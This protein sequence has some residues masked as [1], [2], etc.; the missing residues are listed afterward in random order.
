[1]WPRNLRRLTRRCDGWW[2]RADCPGWM[3]RTPCSVS[4]WSAIRSCACCDSSPRVRAESLGKCVPPSRPRIARRP[5]D[6]RTPSPAPPETCP[7][8]PFGATRRP[9]NSPSSSTRNTSKACYSRSR[10]KPPACSPE[11]DCS[12][13]SPRNPPPSTS[14]SPPATAPHANFAM[15]SRLSQ[16]IWTSGTWT[17]SSGEWKRFGNSACPVNWLS[18]AG[19]SGT[20]GRL[21][22]RSGL[23]TRPTHGRGPP[24][25]RPAALIA[26]STARTI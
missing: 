24:L 22:P 16:G 2:L 3:W 9:S 10:R 13:R 14:W 17:Q 25:G 6:W 15:L 12:M 11:S 1:M 21:R 8:T 4:V 20:G 7:R 19:G 5:G 26:Q 18:T 23:R